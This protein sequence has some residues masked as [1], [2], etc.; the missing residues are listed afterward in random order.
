MSA[1]A[2]LRHIESLDPVTEHCRIVHLMAGFEFVWDMTRA[3]ELALFRTFCIPRISRLLAATGEFRDRGQRRYD[4]T[5]L[6]M[7]ELM[8]WGYDSARGRAAIARINRIHG[9][10][11]IANED[12][13]YVL[14]TFVLDPIRWID[15]HGRRRLVHAERHGLFYFFQ[16]VGQRMHIRDI[17]GSLAEM[18]QMSRAYEQRHAVY[19]PSNRNV[20]DATLRI[21][22]RWLP[23]GTRWMVAPTIRAL[24]DEPMRQ[25]LGYAPPP[26]PWAQ[27]VHAVLGARRRILRVLPARRRSGFDKMERSR[28]HPGGYAIEEL[29]AVMPASPGAPG[30]GAGPR[31]RGC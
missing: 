8:R 28:T 21:V 3:L 14:S 7:S 18:T 11:R 17:P 9:R 29:G 4:D 24:I 2:R 30:P 5:A 23:P 6:L 10:F 13:L 26:A 31:R 27:A 1:S 19:A 20:A 25:A 16:A 22:Q 15:A 12:F